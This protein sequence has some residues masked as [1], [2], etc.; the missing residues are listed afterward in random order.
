MLNA[1]FHLGL[2][3]LYA[4][5]GSDE[6]VLAGGLTSVRGA[7]RAVVRGCSLTGACTFTFGRTVV[8]GRLFVLGAGAFAG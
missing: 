5:G 8:I 1:C 3:L 7:G 2:T 6:R 4:V